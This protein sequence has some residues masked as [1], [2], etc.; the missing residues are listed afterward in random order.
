MGGVVATTGARTF[1]SSV[2]RMKCAA[3]A[4]H[5]PKQQAKQAIPQPWRR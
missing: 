4:Y 5:A 1:Q 2:H 3:T